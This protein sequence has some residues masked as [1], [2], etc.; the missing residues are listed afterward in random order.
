MAWKLKFLKKLPK[1]ETLINV[2]SELK[3]T[4]DSVNKAL[5]LAREPAINQTLS[6]KELTL[7]TKWCFRSTG[8]SLMIENNTDHEIQLKRKTFYPVAFGSKRIS[9]AQLKMSICSKDFSAIYIAFHDLAHFWCDKTK[10]KMFW[11]ITNQWLGS[12]RIKR[13][14]HRCGTHVTMCCSWT[15]LKHKLRAQSIQ[16]LAFSPG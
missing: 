9:P 12:F 1:P 6:G 4:F 2:T 13:F 10:P 16:H 7:M 15:S 11:Q 14:R 8:Y 5:Y 3:E